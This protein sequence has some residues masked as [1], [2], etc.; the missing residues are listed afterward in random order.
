MFQFLIVTSGDNNVLEFGVQGFNV[1][2]S[3]SCLR[4]TTFAFALPVVLL[5]VL[6]VQPLSIFLYSFSSQHDGL[7]EAL[8]RIS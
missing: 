6:F 2:C 5:S 7:S 8:Q 4:H 3:S 1:E